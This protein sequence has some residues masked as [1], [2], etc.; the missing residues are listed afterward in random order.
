MRSTYPELT[1]VFSVANF[2]GL[3]T[4]EEVESSVPPVLGRRLSKE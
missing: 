2:R 4:T 3:V 1:P